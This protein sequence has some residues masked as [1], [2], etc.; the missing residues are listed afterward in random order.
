MATPTE[1]LERERLLRLAEEYRNQG[2]EVF[3]IQILKTYLIF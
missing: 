3:F 2:Y 1:T